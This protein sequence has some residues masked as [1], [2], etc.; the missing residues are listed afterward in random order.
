MK[1]QS[2]LNPFDCSDRHGDRTY[3]SPPPANMPRAVA[4]NIPAQKRQKVPKDAAIFTDA[5]VN[6]PVNF[7]PYED[8]DDEELAAR[9]RKHKVYPMGKIQ[10][11]GARRI[12]YNS[13]KKDFTEK[14]GRDAF[15]G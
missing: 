13:G 1:I 7:P 3:E 6:G 15:E 11:K 8:G 12:P 10:E 5:K 9:H 2:L 4:H 14:T